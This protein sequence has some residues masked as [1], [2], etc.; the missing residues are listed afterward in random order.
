MPGYITMG[1]NNLPESHLDTLV[2]ITFGLLLN[3]LML[4]GK[5]AKTAFNEVRDTWVSG[6]ALEI[7]ESWIKI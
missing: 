4:T 5:D 7:F 1:E 3:M 2:Y 6:K